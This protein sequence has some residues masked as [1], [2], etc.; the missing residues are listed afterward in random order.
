[1]TKPNAT[2]ETNAVLCAQM[3]D[4]LNP[5]MKRQY[6][7][8]HPGQTSYIDYLRLEDFEDDIVVG[9]DLGERKFIALSLHV[10]TYRKGEVLDRESGIVTFHERYIGRHDLWVGAGEL[11]F[12]CGLSPD[13]LREMDMRSF[14][15]FITGEVKMFTVISQED[16]STIYTIESFRPA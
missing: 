1:M 16:N 8:I 15:K 10:V 4:K 7:L 13:H 3:W 11:A 14:A 5:T 12:K 2:Q 6:S 9:R